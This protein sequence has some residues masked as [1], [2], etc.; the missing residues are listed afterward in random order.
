MLSDD[1][2]NADRLIRLGSAFGECEIFVYKDYENVINIRKNSVDLIESHSSLG[3]GC[4][5]FLGGK[6]GYAHMNSFDDTLIENA[7]KAARVSKEKYFYGLPERNKFRFEAVDKKILDFS[8]DAEEISD[9][10]KIFDE[11][12]FLSESN[13]FFGSC[14]SLILNSNGVSGEKKTTFFGVEGMCN[15]KNDNGN[16]KVSTS[17]DGVSERFI[18]DLSKFGEKLRRSAIESS[19]PRRIPYIPETVVFNQDTFSELLG[20][21]SDNF[22]AKNVEKGNSILNG[23]IGQKILNNISIIDDPEMEKGINS[24][25]FDAEGVKTKKKFLIDEGVLKSF[26]YDYNT[27]RKFNVDPT[28]NAVRSG[29]SKP[30]IGFHNLVVESKNHEKEIFAGV[31]KGIYVCSIIGVHTSDPTTT[32]FSVKVERGFLVEHGEIKYPVKDLIISGRFIDLEIQHLSGE[33]ENRE[34]IYTP[35]A[36]CKNVSVI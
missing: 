7:V 31:E 24:T 10:I 4:R 2:Y 5:V 17:V 30:S 6:E 34:G 11:K 1:L 9:Y 32:E 27:A 16:D 14:E 22:D 18:F 26:I 35:C 28:G 20:V 21:F 3:V 23:K 13:I 19:N 29:A 8:C 15:H 36:V 12:T 33:I 25:S